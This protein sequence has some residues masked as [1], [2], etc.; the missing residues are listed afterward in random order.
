MLVYYLARLEIF[1][2]PVSV[3]YNTERF[4]SKKRR[5]GRS[6]TIFRVI[7]C[8]KMFLG[9]KIIVYIN[10]SDFKTA[11]KRPSVAKNVPI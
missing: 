11:Q 5:F 2:R 9:G 3:F 10:C 7:V 6:V 4:S 1:L 8:N